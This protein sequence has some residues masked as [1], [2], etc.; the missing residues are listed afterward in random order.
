M[1]QE[2]RDRSGSHYSLFMIH[3]SRPGAMLI[4][5][6]VVFGIAIA[7]VGFVLVL[8][9]QG[10]AT[11]QADERNQAQLIANA[12]LAGARTIE[13]GRMANQTDGAPRGIILTTGQWA[14]ENNRLARTGFNGN[15]RGAIA[16]PGDMRQDGVWTTTIDEF[17]NNSIDFIFRAEDIE[18]GYAL[19]LTATHAAL[20]I[21]DRGNT[22]TLAETNLTAPPQVV[23]INLAGNSIRTT[24]NAA[25]LTATD[26]TYGR[27][28]F[29]ITTTLLAA[30]SS[31]TWTNGSTTTWT[32][33]GNGTLPPSW[34][35]VGAS[36]LRNARVLLT[37]A[38]ADVRTPLLRPISA[39]V[40][41][42]SRRGPASITA[43]TWITAN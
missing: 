39:T 35:G 13:S 36:A 29:A 2:L 16:L 33:P 27:G 28:W 25:T 40:Q 32:F 3:N 42:E 30:F 10:R 12:I 9:A 5:A 31:I 34:I 37:I 19:R 24:I 4:E 43:E 1:N 8:A 38:P 14:V 26:A 6:I 41:W 21:L 17:P 11:K 22:T 7:L 18:N 20:L 15:Q 23:Q